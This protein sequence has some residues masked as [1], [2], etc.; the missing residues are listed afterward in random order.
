MAYLI[1]SLKFRHL[2]IITLMVSWTCGYPQ[3]ANWANQE[4]YY[5]LRTYEHIWN[6]RLSPEEV[7][8]WQNRYILAYLEFWENSHATLQAE[9]ARSK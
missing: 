3:R 7:S 1:S 8:E 9:L 2:A 5:T 4:F 6:T